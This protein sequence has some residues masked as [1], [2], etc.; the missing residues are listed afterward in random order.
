MDIKKIKWLSKKIDDKE[1]FYEFIT[2]NDINTLEYIA[3]SCYKKRYVNINMLFSMLVNTINNEELISH[4]TLSERKNLIDKALDVYKFPHSKLDDIK[5]KMLIDMV[6]N[7][8]LLNI[9]GSSFMGSMGCQLLLMDEVAST[10]SP[11]NNE[12]KIKLMYAKKIV[13]SSKLPFRE[14]LEFISKISLITDS[15]EARLESKV[16]DIHRIVS[17]DSYTS[18]VNLCNFLF[19]EVIN[20]YDS[21]YGKSYN[22]SILTDSRLKLM[23]E[24]YNNDLK[25]TNSTKKQNETEEKIDKYLDLMEQKN[26]TFKRKLKK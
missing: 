19:N 8:E 10:S 20:D 4:R 5:F 3:T 7:E 16:Y 17:N 9:K 18:N 22:S 1:A 2:T 12:G 11:L 23:L 6:T 14:K 26:K 13:A 24:K 15:N 25:E 21:E